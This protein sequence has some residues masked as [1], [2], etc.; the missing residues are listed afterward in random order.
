[1]KVG[2]KWDA[3][4]IG[5]E[6][7]YGAGMLVGVPQGISDSV[8]SL[9][10]A[11]TNP[12]ATYDAIKQLITSDDMSSTMSDAV[13][14]SYIDRINLME[15][16]YQRAGAGGAYNAGLEACKLM[17]DLITAVAGGVGVAKTGTALTEKIVA[18]VTS[19][20]DKV[21]PENPSITWTA[22]DGEYSVKPGKDIKD[23]EYPGGQYGGNSLP[24]KTSTEK[25]MTTITYP[26]G[27]NIRIDQP[28]HLATVDGFTQKSGISGGHNADAFY[29][30]V[31]KYGVK[32]VSE[33]PTKV[34]DISEVEY[35]APTKDRAGNLTG[36]YK[37]SPVKK[38]IYDPK[39]YTGKVMLDLGQ[40][41]AMKG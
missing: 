33:K 32:I 38:T 1:M 15:S 16:E 24:Y 11:V 20:V 6:A 13:K 4:D 19:K 12:A 27:M 39:I 5:Q 10:K 25:G 9:S 7:A 30:T 3:I 28:K 37:P 41:A 18:K 29:D 17:S 21:I 22:G 2:A 36:E 23:V 14:Q 31:K 8:E 26:D 34:K 35:L 40:E